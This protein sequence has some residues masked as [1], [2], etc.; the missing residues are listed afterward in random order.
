MQMSAML[1][2][3]GKVM[4]TESDLNNSTVTGK[5][6]ADFN[7]T[8]KLYNDVFS[9]TSSLRHY[10]FHSATNGLESAISRLGKKLIFDLDKL[11]IWLA[12]GGSK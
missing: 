3:E 2:I 9:S 12:Q 10:V 8:V 5:R 4:T 1:N 6:F 11:D 7:N